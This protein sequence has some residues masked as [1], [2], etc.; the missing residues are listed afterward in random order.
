MNEHGSAVR[1]LAAF[2]FDPGVLDA[3]GFRDAGEL[4]FPDVGALGRV[5][6]LGPGGV[7][8]TFEAP[9]AVG[10][11]EMLLVH[12]AIATHARKMATVAAIGRFTAGA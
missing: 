12:P 1:S 5:E 9:A 2:G 7:G 8:A 6:P 4:G 10:L 11:P 3:D